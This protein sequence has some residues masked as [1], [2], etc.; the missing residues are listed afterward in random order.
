MGS[1]DDLLII[2]A[3]VA[4]AVAY[5]GNIGGFRTWVEQSAAGGG[6]GGQVGAPVF[7]T[8]KSGN[9]SWDTKGG[10]CW[11]SS[12]CGGPCKT[13]LDNYKTTSISTGCAAA[14]SYFLKNANRCPKCK[15][16][17]VTGGGLGGSTCPYT[18]C[19]HIH[20]DATACNQCRCS[21]FCRSQPQP[22]YPNIDAKGS[23]TCKKS[24]MAK[25][26][27]YE[28]FDNVTVS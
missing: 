10:W 8:G 15:G 17:I 4:P 18:G 12:S 27:A 2:A 24:L 13:C 23:C 7:T 1:S 26:Y 28:G 5:I 19:S 9:C 11:S 14:R 6:G 3:V 21:N 22:A 25:A 16:G 20:A